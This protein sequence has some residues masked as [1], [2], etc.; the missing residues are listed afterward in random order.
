MYRWALVL[1]E[2]L[3]CKKRERLAVRTFACGRV[4][5]S[6]SPDLSQCYSCQLTHAGVMTS[7]ALRKKYAAIWRVATREALPDALVEKQG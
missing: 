7:A 5:N 4:D 1:R 3:K 6:V 2:C